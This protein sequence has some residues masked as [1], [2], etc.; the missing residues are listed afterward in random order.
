MACVAA[1]AAIIENVPNDSRPNTALI[2]SNTKTIPFD[3]Y[4]WGDGRVRAGAQRGQADLPVDRLFDVPLV[5]RDGA[6]ELREQD[7]AE[8]LNRHFVSIKVDREERP[9]VDR[10]YMTF[11]QATTGSGA[12]R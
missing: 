7:V 2:S 8:V 5:P 3:W 11:V 12:G 4:P 9:D 1:A 10:V 6:R